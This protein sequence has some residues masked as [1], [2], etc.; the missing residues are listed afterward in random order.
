MVFSGSHCLPFTLG[1]GRRKVG[2]QVQ[3]RNSSFSGIR[4]DC[5]A[6]SPMVCAGKGVGESDESGIHGLGEPTHRGELPYQQRIPLCIELLHGGGLI[7]LSRMNAV[8]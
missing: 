7:V 3:N 1:E 5:V 4:D 8:A 6:D 2:V